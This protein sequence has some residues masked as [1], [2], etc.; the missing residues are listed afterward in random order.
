METQPHNLPQLLSSFVGREPEAAEVRRMLAGTRL[1]T[2]TGA[3]GVGKTRLALHV[4]R[5]LLEDYPDGVWLVELSTLAD[6]ALV[7]QAV[8]AALGVNE[9]AGRPSTET[10]ADAL[11]HR[12]LLLVLDNCE[13]L[14]VTCAQLAESL[15]RAC[16]TVQVLATSREPLGIAGETSWRVP[17]LALPSN[18]VADLSAELEDSPA[19][20]LFVERACSAF[21]GF[22]LSANTAPAVREICQ[23]LDGIPLAIELAAAQVTV[24]TPIEIA[25]RLDD[26]FRLL[27]RGSRTAPLR[28]QTLRATVEWSY[29]LLSEGERQLFDRLSTFVGGSTLETIE[30]VC[31]ATAEESTTLLDALASLVNQS[32]LLAEPGPEGTMRYRLLEPLRQY[33]HERLALHP[34]A[35]SI[36]A[37]H[38]ACFLD[39]AER[40]APDLVGPHGPAYRTWLQR[41]EQ[42]HDNLRAALQWLLTRDQLEQAL[43][44]G[45]ALRYFWMFQGY[46]SEGRAWLA[47]LIARSQ[48]TAPSTERARVLS[49]AAMLAVVQ[50]D[51]DAAWA[52]AR[53]AE[54]LWR[55][56]DN[57]FERAIVLLNLGTAASAR[58]QPSEARAF[59]EEGVR[60]SRA[61]GDRTAEALNRHGL[62]EIAFAEG[63]YPTARAHAEEAL[64]LARAMG[65][66]SPRNSP[67]ILGL[68]GEASLG[69]GDLPAARAFF[70]ESL[71]RA[72]QIG[73][74]WG[75]ALALVRIGH[76]AAE[77]G[78]LVYAREALTEALAMHRAQG[79]RVGLLAVLAG[80]A[81][82]ADRGREPSRALRLA[83]ATTALAET[84]NTGLP[85]TE[86]ARLPRW[87]TA[88]T[89]ALG[90]RAPR[91]VADG[92]ALSLEEAIAT[93]LATPPIKSQSPKSL[94]ASLAAG[95]PPSGLTPREEEVVALVAQ[96][97]T[98]RRIADHLV[99]SERT[100]ETHVRHALDK[101]E[102]TSR[103]GLA[104]WALQHNLRPPHPDAPQP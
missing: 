6:P 41:M 27:T 71:T 24:L 82:L 81:H 12:T 60:I 4:A 35:D 101:L 87:V 33:G 47:E 62:S 70:E 97:L 80:F 43:R 28:Q 25:A 1:L 2:L 56:L 68:L 45:G 83:G 86:L 54:A 104:T 95:S 36:A 103:V 19:I 84:L 15:L 49:G 38:A 9:Q 99:I 44:M 91:E 42:E 31:A 74:A 75:V 94:G 23:R 17:S 78:D 10:L 64:G 98:N 59:H 20:R 34:D 55:T 92:R 39:L 11:N 96:G 85:P 18:D 77:Q 88:S 46:V 93:A 57:P 48:E 66:T 67:Q 90:D 29:A 79:N 69:E 14:V 100:V 5:E 65:W 51:Y 72:R 30:A 102:L 63:D 21:P 76:V 32:L 61:A 73:W 50:G 58:G 8:A 37:R 40:A 13:H 16:P 89:R 22:T 53:E 52:W 3:G 7:P 26:C